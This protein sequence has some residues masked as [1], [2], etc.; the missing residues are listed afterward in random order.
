VRDARAKLPVPEPKLSR[1][2]LEQ[3]IKKSQKELDEA[4]SC[5]NYRLCDEINAQ[6]DK[7]RAKL[8]AIPTAS[9][10]ASQIAKLEGELKTQLSA[11]AYVK[12]EEI[13]SELKVLRP[14][15][16]ALRDEEITTVPIV[17]VK[18]KKTAKPSKDTPRVNSSAVAP[19]IA[20]PAP[21]GEA[22]PSRAQAPAAVQS[23]AYLLFKHFVF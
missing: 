1:A 5:K 15:Y 6:I 2:D 23:S 22:V 11:K 9:G 4:L 13:E 20:A 8:D 7:F 10:I 21:A 17:M 16:E 12:C 18:A 3:Y 19:V 14:Q